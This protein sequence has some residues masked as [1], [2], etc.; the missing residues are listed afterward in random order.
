M[1]NLM[2]NGEF[3]NIY[4]SGSHFLIREEGEWRLKFWVCWR[5]LYVK[6]NA[7][8]CIAWFTFVLYMLGVNIFKHLKL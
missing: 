4:V 7:A 6:G 8:Y 3:D 1:F 2:E 5:M